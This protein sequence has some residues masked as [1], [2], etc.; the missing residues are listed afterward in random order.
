MTQADSVHSMP[1]KTASKMN[2]PVD[3]TRRHLFTIA[4]G[5]AVAAVIPT[6]A[7]SAAPAI[8]PV[9]DLIAAKRAADVA[10]EETCNVTSEAEE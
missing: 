2:P 7:L 3:P 10:H 4:A 9:F 1:R 6:A 8:D 5:G